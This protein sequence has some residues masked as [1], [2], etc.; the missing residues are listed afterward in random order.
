MLHKQTGKHGCANSIA[1]NLVAV[2]PRATVNEARASRSLCG[3]EREKEVEKLAAYVT[4]TLEEF[5]PQ[6]KHVGFV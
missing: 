2:N 3:A 4:D 5:Q 1:Y 6:G